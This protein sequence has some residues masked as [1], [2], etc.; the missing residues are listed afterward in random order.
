MKR[1]PRRPSLICAALSAVFV[2]AACC[3]PGIEAASPSLSVILPRG[4]QRGTETVFSF[5]GQRLADAEE[6]LFYEPGLTVKN[7]EAKNANQVDVTIAIAPDCPLGVHT[8]QVRTRSGISDYRTLFVGA[9]PEVAEAEPNNEFE[10]PQSVELN[11]CVTGVVQSEDVDYFVVTAKKGQRLTAEIEGMRLGTTLFDP[12][13]AIL[14]SK[15]FELAA[16]DDSPLAQQDSIVS[17]IVPEDG[18]YIIEV[19]ESA[20]GGNGN[21]HYRLHLGTF[22]RPRAVYPAGGQVGQEA[23]VRFLGDAAGDMVTKVQLP[24][25]V[26]D[27]Y[28]LFAED[29]SGIAPSPNPFRLFEH[30]NA[31]EQEPNNGIADATSVELPL[32]FNGII[33]EEGDVDCFRFTAKKGQSFEVECYARRVRSPLDPVMNLYDGNGKSIA[34]NDDSRGPDSYLRF[35]VPADGEYVVRVTD[36]LKQGGPEFVYRIEFTPVQPSLTLGIPRVARYSQSRQQIFVP[37]GNRFATLISASRQNF[38]GDLVLDGNALP[39]GITMVAEAMPS[40]LNVMPVVFEA[41]ADAP[42]AGKLVDFTARH[43]DESTGIRGRFTNRADYVIGQPGQSLYVW[44]DVER[45]PVA[46][47]EEVPFQLEIVQPKVPLVRNGSMQLKIVAHKKEGW[48]EQINVQFPFRPPGVGATSSVN[49]PKGQN[50]VL[51]PLSANGNAQIGAFPVY[52]L[53]SANVDGPAWVSSQMATLE[54]SEPYVGFELQRAAV[55]QGQQAEIVCKVD[56][57]KAFEGAAQVELVGLP[58]RVTAEPLQLTKDITELVFKVQ[59]D[60]ASPAGTHK[61]IFCR[62]L[63]PEQG[64]SVVHARVGGTELRIDKPLPPKVAQAAP[65]PQKT[66]KKPEPE[67]PAE[68]RLSRLEK[69]RLE[70]KARAEQA[71]TQ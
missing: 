68:K 67:Q 1:R 37:R 59:T 45:L 17:L 9:L 16:E 6:V 60:E 62:V 14:N 50:E 31:F 52:A 58:N 63:V 19:R 66:E 15:R 64:E 36:H 70:A 69:L 7:I 47:V 53:G 29:D 38:G 22:P 43:A 46:V 33:Q 40:N 57:L 39:E 65:K 5:R 54:I 42:V 41:A 26:I 48:D 30:G 35:N 25:T 49:I 28:G 21:C 61:N 8:A 32:A 20:Y 18:Q 10:Q 23:E 55:E 56:H 27:D 2:L 34:G 4:G 3:V 44:R 11:Q 24:E 12:Y 51:Y 13:L 71:G